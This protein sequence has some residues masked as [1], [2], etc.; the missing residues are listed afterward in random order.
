MVQYQIG[1]VSVLTLKSH[2]LA[3]SLTLLNKLRDINEIAKSKLSSAAGTTKSKLSVVT[4]SAESAKSESP[5]TGQFHWY[6]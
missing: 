5:Y 2:N 1:S 4:D 6:C 3:E